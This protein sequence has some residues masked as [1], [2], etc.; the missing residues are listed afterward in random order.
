LWRRGWKSR[1]RRRRCC[2]YP[3]AALASRVGFRRARPIPS[4]CDV[5]WTV[6]PPIGNVGFVG[7][8]WTTDFLD[9]AT[10]A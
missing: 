5:S 4:W 8:A 2:C 10:R 6:Q 9:V 1:C 7:L 3:L